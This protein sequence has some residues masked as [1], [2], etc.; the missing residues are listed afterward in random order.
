MSAGND[1]LYR[2]LF[3]MALLI[4]LVEERVIALYPSDRIQSPVHLSV[5]QE[6]VAV[7]VCDALRPD[8]L[9]FATYRSHG[10]YIAKGGRLDEMFAELY[11]RLGGVSKGKAGSMHLSAPEAGLM[12]SSA[13]VASTIPH[14]VGAALSFKRRG[15]TRVAVAVFGDG[16]T[17]E[18]V[19]HESLNFA[20]LMK[21]PVL[22]T[23][24][25]NGLAVHSHRP[26]RQSYNLVKHAAT[27]GIPSRRVE[28]GWDMIAVRDATAAAME[29]VRSGE[30]PFVLEFAT[31]RYMEHVGIG[32][33][34]HFG[35]RSKA[36]TDAWKKRD[37]LIT[38]V[39]LVK[40]LTPEIE[41]EIEDAVAFAE[42]SPHP[43]R[44][45]LLTDVI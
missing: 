38:D 41:R 8:D 11:G 29:R 34:F 7:G 31:S 32:E 1:E 12:G 13:V 33:D 35:Y 28:E 5:G 42:R 16:A 6:A 36:D 22:F 18:G 15:E 21:V 30:G 45:E 24:E 17:E 3:R 20:A 2:R 27:Y 10:F 23:C 44:H 39:D 9:V 4:R 37:P 43:D 14:A 19:Y 25:D 26:V 40:A